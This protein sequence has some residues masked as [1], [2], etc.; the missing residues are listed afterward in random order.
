MSNRRR[1]IPALIALLLLG[2]ILR[3]W[4]LG[5]KAYGNDEATTSL[6]V[7]GGTLTEYRALFDG[8]PRKASALRAYQEQLAGTNTGDVVAS[9]RTEDPQHPP[10]YYVL[11][12]SWETVAA[13]PWGHRAL[14][15][16]FGVAGI[17][18]AAWL[19]YECS[20]SA[21]AALLAAALCAVSPYFI[22]YSQQAREYSLW[23]ALTAVA[24][25]LALR[26][27]RLGA[28]P[29]AAVLYGLTVFAGLQ[30]ALLF[31]GVVLAHA[32]ATL[33]TGR[34]RG[35]VLVPAAALAAGGL[36]A[37][38][39][40]PAVAGN[41]TA[42]T[43]N[44]FLAERLPAKV[45]IAKWLVNTVAVF[46]DGEL[47]PAG[48]LGHGALL[49]LTSFTALVALI[50][51]VFVAIGLRSLDRASR[52]M[53]VALALVP[54]AL[55]AVPDLLHHESR[56]TAARY[57]TPLWVALETAAA[58][59]AAVAVRRYRLW[60]PSAVAAM[61]ALGIISAVVREPV[62]AW[63]TD[64]SAYGAVV[65]AAAIGE[66]APA[67]RRIAFIEHPAGW[68]FAVMELVNRV[69]ADVVFQLYPDPR[70]WLADP[71]RPSYVL[72]AD[73]QAVAAAETAGLHAALLTSPSPRL[74][75]AI[76][77]KPA[78]AEAAAVPTSLVEF[79]KEK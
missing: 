76:F 27:G 33:F 3:F 12:R 51:A 1:F 35:R 2:A 4:G 10:L 26:I 60:G 36:F 53:L 55:L 34:G 8:R 22:L 32:G 39:W 78:A 28:R 75:P 14:A 19:A 59:G 9:L 45:F 15:A 25:A 13:G 17:A 52:T 21:S 54:A 43:N 49:A 58:C 70:A 72:D 37:L 7:A 77:A 66:I 31:A 68:D 67:S 44:V 46:G 24:T 64:W 73:A 74:G 69:P 18:A 56:S 47:V 57:L 50:A 30:T 62:P 41:Q 65:Q 48:Y 23:A 42:V 63:W 6:R 61:L 79:V 5:V 11:N 38:V 71:G 20:L 16:L 40:L 29:F